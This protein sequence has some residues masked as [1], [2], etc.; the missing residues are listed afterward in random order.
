MS[1]KV[2]EVKHPQVYVE[3]RAIAV[4][5]RD[6]GLPTDLPNPHMTVL[7]RKSGFVREE[8]CELNAIID[9]W[10]AGKDRLSF[11]LG[12]Y[13]PRSRKIAGELQELGEALRLGF[14]EWDESVNRPFH[15]EL[16]K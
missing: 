2:Y 13:G 12:D 4:D 15:V 1:H 9:I 7:W 14:H 10:M 6:V 8:A 5:L 11:T 3:G 16:R